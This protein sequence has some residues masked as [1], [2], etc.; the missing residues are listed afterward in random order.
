MEPGT[1]LAHSNR[2]SVFRGFIGVESEEGVAVCL[3][4]YWW[5][6]WTLELIVPIRHLSTRGLASNLGP[7]RLPGCG[8]SRGGLVLAFHPSL[9][10]KNSHDGAGHSVFVVSGGDEL[11]GEDGDIVFL[12]ELL[13]GAGDGFSGLGSQVASAVEAEELAGSVAGFN[14]AIGKQG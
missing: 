8:K 11:E 7:R 5:L 3:W 14:H 1:I 12:A 13:G 6:S 4:N 10:V 2:Q 9:I